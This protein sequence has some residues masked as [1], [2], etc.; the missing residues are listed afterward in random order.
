M[1]LSRA[2]RP[3]GSSGDSLQLVSGE[4]CGEFYLVSTF[5]PPCQA[6]CHTS[7]TAAPRTDSA[8][9]LTP[10]SPR[11]THLLKFFG[12]IKTGTGPSLDLKKNGR[13]NTLLHTPFFP[14][15][16]TDPCSQIPR[17][18]P[19]GPRSLLGSSAADRRAAHPAPAPTTAASLLALQHGSGAGRCRSTTAHHGARH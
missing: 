3:R 8:P 17:R 13:P 11:K 9:E 10:L 7:V 1:Y 18:V 6:L 16:A 14:Y 15:N 19:R 5:C 4:G 2:R 12:N